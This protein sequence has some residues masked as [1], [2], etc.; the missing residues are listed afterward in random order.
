MDPFFEIINSY[1]YDSLLE[2]S[3]PVPRD[4]PDRKPLILHCISLH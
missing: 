4:K 3:L 1:D 2:G